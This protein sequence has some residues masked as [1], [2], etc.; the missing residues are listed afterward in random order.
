M[1]VQVRNKWGVIW[2]H[3][4]YLNYALRSNDAYFEYHFA[5]ALSHLSMAVDRRLH[6]RMVQQTIYPNI[7]SFCLG[8]STVSRKTTAA[9]KGEEMA[10]AV[11]GLEK[12]L[13][14]AGSPEAL[15]E[16]L[17]DTPRGVI[18][19]DEAGQTL[20]E[21]QKTYMGDIKD[22]FCKLYENQ[23]DHRKLRTSQRK[24]QKT[25]F[26]IVDPYITV[27]L[28]TVPDVF[29]EYTN[30]LDVT[31]GWLVRFLYFTPDY[32][33]P[34]MP[35][36]PETEEDI[37]AWAGALTSLKNIYNTIQSNDGE[38][39]LSQEALTVFQQWQESS[40]R[41]LM[42]S[43]N[44]IEMA[45]FGRLVTYCLKIALLLTISENP[46]AREIPSRLVKDSISLIDGYFKLV[47]IELI[48]EIGL[49]E[50]NNLQD[51]II[52][53]IKRAGERITQRQLLK[54][55]HRTLK[56]VSEAIEALEASGE[57][58]VV[59]SDSRVDSCIIKLNVMDTVPSVPNVPTVP[60]EKGI[61][62][63]VVDTS[64]NSKD[65]HAR[66]ACKEQ[67]S[68]YGTLVPLGTVE[69]LGTTQE[70]CGICENPRTPPISPESGEKFPT[71]HAGTDGSNQITTNGD[72]GRA[73]ITIDSPDE[74]QKFGSP[75]SPADRVAQTKLITVMKDAVELKSQ[76]ESLPDESA[77]TVITPQ[78]FEKAC[79]GWEQKHQQSINSSNLAKATFDL[80]PQFPDITADDLAALIRRYAK[81]PK[82]TGDNNNHPE[83]SGIIKERNLGSIQIPGKEVPVVEEL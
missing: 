18:W 69:T 48:E 15:I 16:I 72:G 66:D 19:K 77:S 52:A 34:Y 74:S 11:F 36:R 80:K 63:T 22:T 41:K 67:L 44:K 59:Q 14:R 47:A 76:L 23:G 49:D 37:T 60:K 53:T 64:E 68:S 81:I 61:N 65:I 55:L 6:I 50:R 8:D 73:K 31:S 17:S 40:E 75:A 21:M 70:I 13:P 79:K 30:I 42:E 62:G 56:D 43:R 20:K 29:K 3:L 82:P 26:K 45:I 5:A 51:K 38:V 27:F 9:K 28:A 58:V 25:E 35:F 39:R 46:E 2:R 10:A 83:H 33:K 54:R 32:E 4:K 78:D 1:M 71:T 57:I 24:N 7:W 12:F